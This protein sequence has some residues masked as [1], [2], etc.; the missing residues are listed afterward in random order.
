MRSLNA[1]TIARIYLVIVLL[2]TV[3]FSQLL[4]LAIALALL[5]IQL[6]CA[7]KPPK[8]A[9]NLVIVVASLVFAPLAFQALVGEIFAVL[10]IVPVLLLLDSS[11]K[12]YALDQSF[13]F[14][15]IGRSS[16]NILKNLELCFSVILLASLVLFNLPLMLTVTV[17]F[18]YLAITL[19]YTYR[20][21]PTN[22][23]EE[24]KTWSRTI[25]G[26][27]D[28]KT[29]TLKTNAKIP[30]KIFLQPVDS[31]VKLEP[32]LF[33]LTSQA[34]TVIQFTPPLAGPSKISVQAAIVDSRGLMV[35]NQSLQPLDL[36]IIPRAKY[37]K[38]LANKFLKETSK[39]AGIATGVAKL[40]RKAGKFGV[41]FNSIRP[42][43]PGDSWRDFDWKHTYMLDQLIVKEFS[44]AQG[45][46]GIIVADLTAKNA[47]DADV[48]AYNL[49]MSALTLAIEALP[50]ALA[51][52]NKY[53]V[54]A[55]TSPI[56]PR[57]ALKKTL[58]LTE[59]ITIEE[60]KEKILQPLELRRLKRSIS[61]LEITK[62]E[63]AHKLKEI[64]EFEAEASQQAAKKHPATLALMKAVK[65][66]HAP[67]VITVASPISYDSEALLLGLEQLR[68]KGYR[69]IF[70]EKRGN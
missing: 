52:Y 13:S 29:I 33:N 55:A 41:E 20:K 69:T 43:Q 48:L 15:K 19:L 62:N 46:V 27:P 66:A 24:S 9:F 1:G 68:E 30:T 59:K 32:S 2:L 39:G 44:E 28:S 45:S 34:D 23:L 40:L 4:Q 49:V 17:L 58:E 5:I 70:L 22:A 36:H 65:L 53:E 8:A 14:S 37:A 50:A 57:E 61:Q 3:I 63:T 12:Q 47:E 60:P 67:A 16:T 31:W 7:Y 21:V 64:L 6:Y 42:Y 35:T 51:V 54:F 11:I 56:S 10:L 18:S 25:V 38:W 26:D